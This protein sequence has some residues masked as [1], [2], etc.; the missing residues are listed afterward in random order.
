MLG[1]ILEIFSNRIKAHLESNNLINPKQYGFRESHRTTNVIAIAYEEITF[2]LANKNRAQAFESGTWTN[3]WAPP[4]KPSHA[5]N[6]N[7]T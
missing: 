3:I 6:E 2:A 1:K 4:A 7:P 5:P